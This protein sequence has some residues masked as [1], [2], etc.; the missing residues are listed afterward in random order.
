MR[1]SL[2]WFFLT[3]SSGLAVAQAVLPG[4]VLRVK[5]PHVRTNPVGRPRGALSPLVE[6][7]M[8]VQFEN[9]PSADTLAAFS[10]RGAKVLQ[11][12]P[13]NGILVRMDGTVSLSGLGLIYAETIDAVDKLSPL[14]TSNNPANNPTASTGYYLIEFHPDVDLNFGRALILNVGLSLHENPDLAPQ[15]L[16]VQVA[17]AQQALDA[18]E[19]LAE[20]DEVAY[21]FPA[22]QDLINGTPV[23]P[24]VGA[25]T[26][27]SAVGQ[28]VVSVGDGWD[29]PGQNAATLNYVFSQ[30]T[31]RLPAGVPQ[32]EIERAMAEWSKV[33]QITWQASTNPNGTRTVNI[34]FATGNH[35]D[36]YPFDGPG[37]VLAHTFYPAP[38]NPEPIAGD[39]HFDDAETWRVGANTDLF[40]VALHELGH[41]LGLGHSDNPNA[42]MY[43]Y[44]KMVS[45]LAPYDKSAALTLYAPAQPPASTSVLTLTVNVPPATTTATSVSLSGSVT[46]GS[47]VTS[48]TWASSFGTS[49]VAQLSG[50]AWSVANIPLSTGANNL[51]IMAA[52][53]TES[54]SRTV[55]VTRQTA[56]GPN[57]T[58]TTAPTLTITSPG[59][60]SVATSLA[61]LNF[62]GTASDNVAVA[63]VTWS[64]NT[65]SSGT[66]AG[67]GQWSAT[68]PLLVGSNTVTVRAT[69]TSGNGSWRTVV[70]TRR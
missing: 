29:G 43:P 50:T 20:R 62:A 61:S 37:G 12:V 70:V 41:A 25:L 8:I 51:T 17:N 30:M 1:I 6:R 54:M 52:D 33:I 42:V 39:M 59:S 56:I 35:G 24:C 64:T 48:V 11:D 55:T 32:S 22:S 68:I 58:D 18:L 10:A 28:Y 60:T 63:S 34:L 45:T 13:D 26:T 7:H 2:P 66:A 65:G 23:S 27:I 4:P 16:L 9:P 15:Q 3:L 19:P 36:G 14:I 38:P 21:I 53:G 57:P 47:G 69:D 5:V 44:Y 67:T 46:G 40:S 31:A 49:G